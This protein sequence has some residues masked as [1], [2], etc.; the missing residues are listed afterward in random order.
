[1]WALI[2]GL[3]VPAARTGMLALFSRVHS[4]A[5]TSST[6]DGAQASGTQSYLNHGDTDEQQK[7]VVLVSNRL[8]I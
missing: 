1:M 5:A 6:P 3:I 8:L 7:S 4:L 2:L